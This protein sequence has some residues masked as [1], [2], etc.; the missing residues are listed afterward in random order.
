M[1]GFLNHILYDLIAVLDFYLFISLCYVICL[2]YMVGV[3]QFAYEFEV[4]RLFRV[5]LKWDVWI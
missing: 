3:S 1:M 2:Y 4:H 5:L